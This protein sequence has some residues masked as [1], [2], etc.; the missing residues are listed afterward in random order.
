MMWLCHN[1][2]CPL[3]HSGHLGGFHL[4]LAYSELMGIHVET[5]TGACSG[6]RSQGR[7]TGSQ[8]TCVLS[9]GGLCQAT[10]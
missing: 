8:R 5:H 1:V 3:S 4:G 9:T 2:F 10:F 7:T 6:A